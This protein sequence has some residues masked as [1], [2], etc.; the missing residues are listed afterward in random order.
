[1][2]LRVPNNLLHR[3]LVSSQNFVAIDWLCLRRERL[4]YLCAIKRGTNLQTK[5]ILT[6]IQAKVSLLNE[7][8]Y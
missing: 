8:E 1:M 6:T 4:P 5:L 3:Y 7:K 2:L